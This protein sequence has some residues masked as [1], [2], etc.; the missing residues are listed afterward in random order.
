MTRVRGKALDVCALL[1][2]TCLSL[3]PLNPSNHPVKCD[4]LARWSAFAVIDE[5][6]WVFSSLREFYTSL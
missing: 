4:L 3:T 2:P 6:S 1:P 5:Q